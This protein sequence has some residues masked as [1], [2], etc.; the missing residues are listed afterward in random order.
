[1]TTLSIIV[2]IYNGVAFL[3]PF[4]A[5]VQGLLNEAGVELVMVNDGSADG[6]AE[7]LDA[8]ASANPSVRALHVENGGRAKNRAAV[9][10]GRYLWFVDVDDVLSPARL[11]DC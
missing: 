9:A 5:S 3:H 2:P 6:T 11:H 4:M 7:M 8:I 10:N 1:M